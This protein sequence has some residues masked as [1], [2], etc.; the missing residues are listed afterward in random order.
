MK[1]FFILLLLS[2]F[3]VNAEIVE[4]ATSL[5]TQIGRSV[6]LK[7]THNGEVEEWFLPEQRSYYSEKDQEIPE[8]EIVSVKT[9]E[10]EAVVRA[11]FYQ[12]GKFRLPLAWK[13]QG[14]KVFSSVEFEVESLAAGEQDILDIEGPLVWS[15]NYY[16]RLALMIFAVL[17]AAAALY[18]IYIRWKKN[19]VEDDVIIIPEKKDNPFRKSMDELVSREQV[20]RK[21]LLFELTAYLKTEIEN[22]T[23][24]KAAAM[25][26][27]ELA[28]FL[29]KKNPAIKEHGFVPNLKYLEED[30]VLSSGEAREIIAY[31]KR[32]ADGI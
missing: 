5:K 11:M 10:R 19:R 23:G 8:Y 3:S 12:T 4:E 7:V 28:G 1:P 20:S 18:Y 15:G 25:T 26:D 9:S 24:K 14:K 31:W 27:S 32:I 30:A 21:E 2:V 22:R 6:D 13:E 16:L 29:H 17:G